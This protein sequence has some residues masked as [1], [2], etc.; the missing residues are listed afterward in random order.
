MLRNSDRRYGV[1]AMLFH[2]LTFLAVAFLFGLGLYMVELSYYDPWYTKAPDWH[3]SVGVLLLGLVVLRL[4]WR[5]SNPQP[6]APAGHA[7]WERALATLAHWALYGLLI[8]IPLTGYLMSTADGR[9]VSV[10]GWF[11]VPAL[12]APEKGRE[13]WAGDWHEWLAWAMVGL[14]V[15]HAL[16][17][18]KHHWIDRDTTLTRMLPISRAAEEKR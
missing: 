12:L 18:I 2:W 6:A 14:V 11:E 9:A 3:R 8:I 10:F 15:L 5:L 7:P 16:A 13:D 17:A 4:A 1:A